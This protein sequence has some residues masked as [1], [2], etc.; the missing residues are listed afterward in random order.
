MDSI[1]DD[2]VSMAHR[3]KA[4]QQ[5]VT[6]NVVGNLPHGFLALVTAANNSDMN[7]AT[8]LCLDYMKE[9]LHIVEVNRV[10]R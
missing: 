2:S 3:L 1:L 5:P 8:K 4:L 9:D 7:F 6:L 10:R